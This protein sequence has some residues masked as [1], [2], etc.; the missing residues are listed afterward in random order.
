[1]KAPRS[2]PA[3]FT[4]F[5]LIDLVVPLASYYVLR[6]LGASVWAALLAGAA[7]PTLRLT[8]SLIL[9]RRLPAASLFTLGLITAGTAIGLLT[10]DPRLLMA[11]ESYLT[12]FVGGWLLL[13]LLRPR[14]LVFTA[15]VGFMPPS[16][17]AEW[18]RS[19]ETSETFRRAMRG[20]TW[21][22]GLAFIIDAAARVVMSYSLPL[23]VVPAA[24]AGLLGLMLVV[25]VQ[26]GKAWGRRHMRQSTLSPSS[27]A[28]RGRAASG[29]G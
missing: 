23:D 7:L 9:R 17:A 11:R 2:G 12:G 4:G 8:A 27:S 20:M 29:S 26:T 21:G 1:M 18:H 24:S 14:P 19:W 3:A 5:L 28:P 13:S 16:A 15:T 22:F 25:I 10:A 6:A